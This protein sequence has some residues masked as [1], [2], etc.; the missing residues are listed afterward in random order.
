MGIRRNSGTAGSTG[1]ARPRPNPP[2]D[3]PAAEAGS[4]RSVAASLAASP[5]A[6][7]T[8][9]G[10]RGRRLGRHGEQVA[11]EYLAAAG[12]R[13]LDR[14]WVCRDPDLRGELDLIARIRDTLVVC[15]V[16]TR[17][18]GRLAHPAQ[19]VTLEKAVRLRRLASRWLRDHPD[20][21]GPALDGPRRRAGACGPLRVRIDV[22]AV[23]TGPRP[24]FPLL[25]LDH[26]V[27]VA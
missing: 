10:A 18:G 23:R 8:G 15:E 4:G 20:G 3:R 12:Y 17:S 24:P 11:A 5:A 1:V 7:A 2:R 22:I 19:A 21:S 13:L 14:N 9:P 26:L 27:G 25:T 16:K 6:A